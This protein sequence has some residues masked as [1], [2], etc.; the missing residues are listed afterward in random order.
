[1]TQTDKEKLRMA[2]NLVKSNN[3]KIKEA[4]RQIHELFANISETKEIWLDESVNH[5]AFNTPKQFSI[6]LQKA[7]FLGTVKTDLENI[8]K[9]LEKKT[10]TDYE[11]LVEDIKMEIIHLELSGK[12][13]KANYEM[14]IQRIKKRIKYP[15]LPRGIGG[16]ESLEKS[17]RR[18]IVLLEERTKLK[19]KDYENTIHQIDELINDPSFQGKILF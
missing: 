3:K 11:K 15:N 6:L 13:T 10:L 17:I 12:P 7:I 18:R 5:E 19:K 1:M 9:I 4:R 16:M 2:K 8:K 14:T